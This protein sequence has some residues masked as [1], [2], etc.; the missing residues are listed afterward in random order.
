M[1]LVGFPLLALS[2][3]RSPLLI[4]GVAVAGR[5]P[6]SVIALPA[7]ALA[8]RMNRRRMIVTIE[9]L[10]FLLLCAFAILVVG[11]LDGLVLIYAVVLALGTLKASFDFATVACIPTLVAPERLIR[12][13]AHLMAADLTASEMAGQALGGVAFTAA[14]SIPFAGDAVSFAA[15]ALILRRAVPDNLPSTRETTLLADLRSGL[16]SF[17]QNP[18]LRTL[19]GLVAS[20]AFCQ[21]LVLGLLVLYATEILH[22]SKT[23]Y[24]L[25]LAIGAIGNV[26]GAVSAGTLHDRFG[27][28]W[29]IVIA[30]LGAAAAYPVLAA[31]SSPVVAGAALTL[32]SMA[33][34]LGNIAARSLRQS[35]V[36][37]EL[38][39]RTASA[40]QTVILAAIPLGGL[41][42]G[43][44]AG[45]LGLR[46]TFLL[47]GA[48][49]LS[50]LALA[51]PLLLA[52]VRR[53]SATTRHHPGPVA[54]PKAA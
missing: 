39:G 20:M 28:G 29:C 12:A 7:G 4:A 48:L 23:G 50:V 9:A 34:M 51:A 32:E 3:T 22:L 46:P 25:L 10:R 35:N 33:V 14:Q 38:Q 45:P 44:L 18:L 54:E 21:G 49:Q 36:A 19:T 52:H 37:Q 42:G 27:S 40:Y 24:G 2:F 6:A 5:L 17:L 53:E 26:V 11:G 1:A 30:G 31:T 41:A 47:A 16:R 8:D 13:N 15:S 43:I